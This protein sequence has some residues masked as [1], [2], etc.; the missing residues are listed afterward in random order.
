MLVEPDALSEARLG[1]LSSQWPSL[2]P[3]FDLILPGTDSRTLSVA[4]VSQY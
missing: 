3:L 2:K 4:W 1:F